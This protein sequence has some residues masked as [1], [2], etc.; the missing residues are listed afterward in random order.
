LSLAHPFRARPNPAR[1][2][3]PVRRRVR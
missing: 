3:D 1:P 2:Y